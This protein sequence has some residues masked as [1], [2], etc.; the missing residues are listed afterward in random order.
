MFWGHKEIKV[1]TSEK[2][3]QELLT[4]GVADIIDHDKLLSNLRGGKPLRVKFGIDPTSPNIHLG[5]AAVLWKLRA[6][7]ELGHKIVFII[8]DF[9]GVIGDTSDKDSERPMLTEEVVRKNM[10]EYF[11]QAGK[12]LKTDQVERYY[13]SSWLSK[14]AYKEISE[15]ADKFSVADFIGRE[16][17][18]R[19]LK[20]GTRVSLREVLYPLMQ[21]YDSVKV[22]ADVEIGGTDQRFNMLSGRTL[23][24]HYKQKPQQILMTKL[25]SGLDGRKMS[26]SWGNVININD[27]PNEMYG[28]AMSLKDE[29]I[30]E[31]F[32]LAT[33]IKGEEIEKITSD[34]KNNTLHPKEAKMH[35]ALELV[36]IYHG[37]AAAKSA[38]ENFVKT[39]SKKEAPEDALEV[40]VKG[41]ELLVDILLRT[42]IIESKS[43]FSRLIS[44]KAIEIVGGPK[45]INAKAPALL[46]KTYKI[47]KHRFLKTK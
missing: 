37:V 1:V 18:D 47:G 36:R 25:L 17:I 26:S 15:Q 16:N 13:N 34:L 7:Q 28:K 20:A 40:S 46:G 22:G 30:P 12:I 9:T 42:K 10:K 39:F 23:Q 38:E 27:S 45:I 11:N 24:A 4:R 33:R 43:E 2:E 41:G 6:F 19:R 3:I 32:L 14:L 21:G 31:F 44:S 35:L 29:L 8:G 5:R